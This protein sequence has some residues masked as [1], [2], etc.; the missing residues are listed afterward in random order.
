MISLLTTLAA[1]KSGIPDD[2][3]VVAGWLGFAVFIALIVAVALLCWSFARQ[4]RKARAAKDAGVYGDA[5]KQDP[6]TDQASA[7][8][9]PADH[10][11][12]DDPNP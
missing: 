11:P 4:I 12:T 5:P 2:E 7:E 6:A 1:E 9:A 10:S 8:Q 3:D